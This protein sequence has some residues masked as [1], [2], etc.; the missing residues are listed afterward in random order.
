MSCPTSDILH[1]FLDKALNPTQARSIGE[2]VAACEAC[3][4]ETDRVAR[5]AAAVSLERP[6]AGCLSAPKLAV[7]AA[8]QLDEDSKGAFLVHLGRCRRCADALLVIRRSVVSRTK[9]PAPQRSP[10]PTARVARPRTN[11]GWVAAAALVV[12]CIGAGAWFAKHSTPKDQGTQVVQPKPPQPLPRETPQEVVQQPPTP[13]PQAPKEQEEPEELVLDPREPDPLEEAQPPEQPQEP[14]EDHAQKPPEPVTP[15]PEGTPPPAPEPT[16]PKEQP[17]DLAATLGGVEFLRPGQTAWQPLK[18]GQSV[19][20]EGRLSLKVGGSKPARVTFAGH[21]VS[22]EKN[23]ELSIAL[24]ERDCEMALARGGALVDARSAGDRGLS[25][26]LAGGRV[27]AK[28]GRFL[29]ALSNRQGRVLPFDGEVHVEASG[30]DVAVPRGLACLLLE[31]KPPA[32]PAKADAAALLAWTRDLEVFITVEAEKGR[33]KDPMKART[34]SSASGG[35]YVTSS[36]R[37]REEEAG[38]VEIAFDA[39]R[40]G[41]Y[42]LFARASTGDRREQ[43]AFAVSFDGDKPRELAAR[44]RGEEWAWSGVDAVEL[45]AGRHVVRFHDARGGLRLDSVVITTDTLF[46]PEPA[47]EEA[48]EPAEGD[49]PPR[50]RNPRE[51]PNPGGDRGGRGR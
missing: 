48:E 6:A 47:A 19:K 38:Y 33:I 11:W 20:A 43:G 25:L 46:H 17:F 29:A 15:G 31:G 35:R 51:N 2:H 26:D 37:D 28:G 34:D 13:E 21:A 16:A 9:T 12:A 50:E 36:P 27:H 1:A 22:L 39:K 14:P 4:A 3:A 18:E 32:E 24:F 30:Q 10:R 44:G 23:S 5:L 45:A 7:F 42:R 41:A 49:R 40:A 8:G